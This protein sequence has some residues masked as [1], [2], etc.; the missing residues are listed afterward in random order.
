MAQ[1]CWSLEPPLCHHVRAP[2]SLV[3]RKC[4]CRRHLFF[5]PCTPGPTSM[6]LGAHT[7][8]GPSSS[9]KHK[10]LQIHVNF[11]YHVYLAIKKNKEQSMTF[12]SK[13][14]RK[15]GSRRRRVFFLGLEVTTPSRLCAHPR[16]RDHR[17]VPS[18]SGKNETMTTS[19]ACG[20]WWCQRRV[21][22]GRVQKS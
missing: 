20:I 10:C 1:I 9:C 2:L 15:I 14:S 22:R 7:R 3:L 19:L 6:Y 8:W 4:L 18:T 12:L 13:F 16:G 21:R 11:R 5:D 17:P